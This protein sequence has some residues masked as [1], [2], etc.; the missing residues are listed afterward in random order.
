[1]PSPPPLTPPPA[2]HRGRNG[3]SAVIRD[4]AEAPPALR[5]GVD[6]RRHTAH[7]IHP[8]QAPLRAERKMGGG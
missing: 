1:M 8:N 3:P 6:L 7:R 2:L 4:G 5:L